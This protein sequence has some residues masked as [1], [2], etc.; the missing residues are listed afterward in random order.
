MYYTTRVE[1][2]LLIISCLEDKKTIRNK[3]IFLTK[4]LN[5][6]LELKKEY[7]EALKRPGK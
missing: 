2:K 1:S 3:K 7:Q 4:M 6:M 5:S